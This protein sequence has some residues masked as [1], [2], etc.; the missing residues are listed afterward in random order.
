MRRPEIAI[1]E[2][3]WFGNASRVWFQLQ[4]WE[5]DA[6][7]HWC[8]EGPWLN[9]YDAYCQYP[10]VLHVFRLAQSTLRFPGDPW[11]RLPVD[12][13]GYYLLGDCPYYEDTLKR[14]P[15]EIPP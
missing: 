4:N 8:R 5:R 7:R 14:V 12:E 13:L 3:P 11:I 6:W 10:S 2:D 15:P 1:T 9:A